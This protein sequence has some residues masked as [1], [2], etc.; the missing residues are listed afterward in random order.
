M[1]YTQPNP[2][3]I[4]FTVQAF[5]TRLYNKVK[6]KWSLDDTGCN[7][8]G[9]VARTK[10]EDGYIPQYYDATKRDYVSG[11]GENS[12]G[13]MFFEDTVAAL[14]FMGLVDPIKRNSINDSVASM[15]LIFCINMDKITAGG[16]SISDAAG[17]RMD[18]IAINDVVNYIQRNGNNFTVTNTFKDIDKVWERYS[19]A[20]KRASLINSLHPKFC[21]R[22][23]VELRYDPL[24]NLPKSNIIIPKTMWKSIT[25][26]IKTAPDPTK[27]IAVGLGRYIQQE[28]APSNTLIPMLIGDGNGYLAG[29]QVMKPFSYNNQNESLPVYDDIRGI[30]DRSANATAPDLGFNDGDFCTIT[31][32]DT[33]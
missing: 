1:L 5:I 32:L 10:S 14:F 25:L 27:K 16:I 19:G 20:R 6:S 2:Y 3:G 4:D 22:I 12:D 7:G 21:F 26:F 15:Q 28:Y 13:G 8:F 17:Q 29:R 33:I 23:D 11:T 24:L 30:W 31:F 9:R 18:E